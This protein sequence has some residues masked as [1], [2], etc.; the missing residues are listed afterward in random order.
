[1]PDVRMPDG[2]VVR[3]VP[4]NATR[5]QILAAYERA[6][7]Q[8]AIADKR[9]TSFFRGLRQGIM[10]PVSNVAQVVEKGFDT[11]GLAKPINAAGAY[12]GLA[13]SVADARERRLV[14]DARA[15]TSGS[16]PG[17]ITG[18]IIG[19]LPA[20]AVPG[21][22]V[23]QGA[24]AGGLLNENHTPEGIMQDITLGAL[25]NKAGQIF[26]DRVLQ[27][28]FSYVSNTRAG[29]ALANLGTAALQ[30]LNISP[31]A[32]PQIVRR[33]P[34]LS[35]PE[36]TVSRAGMKP[37]DLARMK[38]NLTAAKRLNVPYALADATP[39][40][41]AL[42][43]SASRIS[44]DA[45]QLAEDVFGPRAYGQADRAVQ[46]IDTHLAPI[47]DIGKRAAEIKASAQTASRPFYDAAR[48]QAAP[49]DEELA[50]IMQRP[51]AKTAMQDAYAT[52]QN[53]GIDPQ[54]IGFNLDDQ[55]EVVLQKAPSFET[56]Q[57][58]KRAL[59][60]QLEPARNLI[61]GKLDLEGRPDL[62][63]IDELRHTLNTRMGYLNEDYAAGNRAYAA[64]IAKR[65]ALN[66]GYSELP[67]GNVNQAR[68]ATATG[69]LKPETLPDAQAGYATAM[70][71]Q[72]EKVRLSGDPFKAVYGSTLQQ[73]K[74]GAMFPEGADN[75]GQI[76][77]LESDMA[78]TAYETL[79]GSPTAARLQA[80]QAF[81]SAIPD[82]SSLSPKAA[83]TKV[84]LKRLQ[85]RMRTGGEAK[86]AA[87]APYLFNT[88]PAAA[89]SLIDDIAV[90]S[91]KIAAQKE[92]YSRLVGPM[93]GISAVGL[94]Q[95]N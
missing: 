69:R 62:Q 23:V 18:N 68:M 29:N 15:S 16:T 72:V 7:Q 91:A 8:G 45:R 33:A 13:P 2:T 14:S 82:I 48:A 10:T 25:G 92:A 9:P 46:A 79:G 67:Q 30:R 28:A 50:A 74:V 57:L 61:T 37:A 47:T 80:D 64:E 88:D 6:K 78:K 40:L 5:Q 38:A 3:N 56:L 85:D 20:N 89:L 95:G 44:Q 22:V 86:A 36:R 66:L 75:F 42:S 83:L 41:R 81:E 93:F 19:T 39:K 55:G 94:A 87:L 35:S 17:R 12:F 84:A 53:R 49:V 63:A 1:M 73:G 60:A 52:A 34:V 26:G 59:D 70:A 58:T 24:V 77:G 43:G 54:G 51:A 32:L 65:D 76:A 4:A 71:D 90:K 21:G 31:T 27:P 11:I